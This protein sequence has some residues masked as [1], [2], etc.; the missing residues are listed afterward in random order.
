RLVAHV[1]RRALVRREGGEPAVEGGGP[2]LGLVAV[3]AEPAHQRHAFGAGRVGGAGVGSGGGRGSGGGARRRR[4]ARGWRWWW[5]RLG[6]SGGLRGDRLV[7][8]RGDRRGGG[9]ARAGREGGQREEQG[10]VADPRSHRRGQRSGRA[11]QSP[12]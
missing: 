4:G 7:R 6:R 11:F 8:G 5:R 2:E 10:G 12:I 3:D 9:G 1:G